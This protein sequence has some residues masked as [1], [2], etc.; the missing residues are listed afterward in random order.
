M[1]RQFGGLVEPP[2]QIPNGMQWHGN[3]DI[4][5]GEQLLPCP[6]HPRCHPGRE[7]GAIVVLECLHQFAGNIAIGG[8]GTQTAERWRVG[9]CV[10]GQC[11]VAVIN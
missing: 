9:K 7:I 10:A 5:I 11:T 4:G 8:D 2:P 6:L 1:A 3:D